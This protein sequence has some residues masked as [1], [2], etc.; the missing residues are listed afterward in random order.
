MDLSKFV[1]QTLSEIEEG[2][3]SARR[4]AKGPWIALGSVGEAEVWEAE[5]ITFEVMVTTV[6]EGGGGIKVLSFGDLKAQTSR[7]AVQKISFN[8]PVFFNSIREEET[9]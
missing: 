9:E 2:V 3:R 7:E 6:A 1:S 4:N 8:I 5:K